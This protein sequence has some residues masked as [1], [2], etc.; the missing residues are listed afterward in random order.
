MRDQNEKQ[1]PEIQRAKRPIVCDIECRNE[2]LFIF[3]SVAFLL[4]HLLHFFICFICWKK[5]C[6]SLTVINCYY[7]R[8][9]NG[10]VKEGKVTC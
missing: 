9:L 8:L 2:E 1:L 3:V 7:Y 4:L 10:F 6:C 5:N